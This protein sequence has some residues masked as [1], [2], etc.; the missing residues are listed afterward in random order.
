MNEI[1]I[2]WK[3]NLTTK[4]VQLYY[5]RDIINENSFIWN[6]NLNIKWEELYWDDILNENSLI[7]TINLKKESYSKIA[8]PNQ[9]SVNSF[10]WKKNLMGTVLLGGYYK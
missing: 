10:I 9:N 3:Y 6:N 2:I 1:S 5:K 4:W 8:N 7:V